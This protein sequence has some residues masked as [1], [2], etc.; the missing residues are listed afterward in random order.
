MILFMDFLTLK[1]SAISLHNQ[2]N[3]KIRQPMSDA[4]QGNRT[5]ADLPHNIF[6]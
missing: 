6:R 4:N 2:E 3:Q 5:N 1:I